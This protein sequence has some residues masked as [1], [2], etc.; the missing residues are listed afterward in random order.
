MPKPY[1]IEALI[2][3]YW[4]PRAAR[5]ATYRE[6]D[7]AGMDWYAVNHSIATWRVFVHVPGE[8]VVARKAA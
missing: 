3:G 1:R 2:N 5:F 6:A 4:I 7:R 8:P